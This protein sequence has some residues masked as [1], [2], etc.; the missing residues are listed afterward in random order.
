MEQI[1]VFVMKDLATLIAPG[2]NGQIVIPFLQNYA[3]VAS[4]DLM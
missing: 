1:T 4:A 3:T 2:A